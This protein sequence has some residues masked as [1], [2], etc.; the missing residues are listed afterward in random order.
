MKAL[1]IDDELA[2]RNVLSNLIKEHCPDI[3]SVTTVPNVPSAVAAIKADRPDIVFLD[4]QMPDQNGFQLFDHFDNPEFGVVFTTAYSEYALKAF[5]VSAI[6]Y[7]LKPLQIS[8]LKAAVKKMAHSQGNK[9][10]LKER[11][12]ILK[13][14]VHLKDIQKIALPA[15]N[16]IT[17]VKTGDIIYLK[18]NGS[19]THVVT[20][21]GELLIS[22][23]IG[24]FENVLSEMPH[25]FRIHRSFIINI[26]HINE[27][28]KDEGGYI[29]MDNRDEIPIAK[30]RRPKF[31]T[32]ISQVLVGHKSKPA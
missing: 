12:D 30:E 4:V 22:K 15:G 3:E 11:I 23:K 1:V 8:Q 24:A 25:F 26:T 32:L 17:F 27:Y 7:L 10:G 14:T 16:R 5:E 18:A 31:E 28:V 19:Y 9:S 2:A 6:D 20:A 21:E 13:E 29:S